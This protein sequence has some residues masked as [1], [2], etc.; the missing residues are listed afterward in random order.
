LLLAT[1]LA[2]P[3]PAIAQ[4]RCGSGALPPCG[5]PEPPPVAAPMADA[6]VAGQWRLFSPVFAALPPGGY[7][8]GFGRDGTAQ[9]RNVAGVTGW[10]MPAIGR[11]ELT[12]DGRVLHRFV[13]SE[14]HG[15][16]RRVDKDDVAA[17]LTMVIAPVGLDPLRTAAA[18]ERQPDET[19]LTSRLRAAAVPPTH[20]DGA[21]VNNPGEAVTIAVD[22]YFARAGGER[23]LR[24]AQAISADR[25][26]FDVPGFA[27]AGDRVWEVRVY[28]R[29]TLSGVIWVNAE[30]GRTRFLAP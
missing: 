16:F 7:P 29:G 1:L 8:I 9:T 13:W 28:E 18:M 14:R 2:W 17:S 22:A 24:S 30:T 12:G 15:A 25:L 26:A 19:D 10:F 27:S 11:I 4:P 21:R 20:L 6:L 3:S 5:A 23:S